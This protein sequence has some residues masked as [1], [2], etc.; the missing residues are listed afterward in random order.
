MKKKEREKVFFDIDKL[1]LEYML[2]EKED[3]PDSLGDARCLIDEYVADMDYFVKLGR[4]QGVSNNLIHILGEVE[5]GF[6][7]LFG[8]EKENLGYLDE[9]LGLILDEV[10]LSLMFKNMFV[11]M[12]DSLSSD[13][14]FEMS[15]LA[16]FVR[17]KYAD[18]YGH[19]ESVRDVIT[20]RELGMRSYPI[21][22]EN[23]MA[24]L[25][26]FREQYLQV[27]SKNVEKIKKI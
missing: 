15:R 4:G 22:E 12:R 24:V 13:N 11:T 16:M 23:R 8:A 17:D 18:N 5:N 3:L 25:E 2:Y 10:A 26:L 14:F 9:D 27:V 6:Y 21:G 19:L 20:N 7:S 1:R